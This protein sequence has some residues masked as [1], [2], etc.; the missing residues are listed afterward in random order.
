MA[1]GWQL[2]HFDALG[3]DGLYDVLELR[4]KVFI[5]EQGAFLDTDRVD[6]QALHLLGRDASGRLQAYA[7]LV[8]PGVKYAEPS[9]GRVITSAEARGS[10]F[11]KAL[12]AQALRHHQAVWPGQGNRIS[13]QARLEAFYAGFGWQRSA[14]DHIEDGIPH[15]EMLWSPPPS[16]PPPK[17]TP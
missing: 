3:V 12:V 6:Q 14:P 8:R 16:A 7:R 4:C 13:A 9:L 5:L 15:T 10:G 17:E 2:L 11:G 1:L